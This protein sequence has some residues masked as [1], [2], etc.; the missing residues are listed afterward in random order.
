MSNETLSPFFG[1]MAG[2]G[3][4]LFPYTILSEVP[5]KVFL[6]SYALLISNSW[7]SQGSFYVYSLEYEIRKFWS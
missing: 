1:Y 7:V 4:K 6:A 5:L 2:L 3:P